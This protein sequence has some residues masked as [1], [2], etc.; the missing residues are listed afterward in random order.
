MNQDAAMHLQIV[1][2]TRDAC[3]MW[4]FFQ[5]INHGISVG[6]IDKMID[7]VRMFLEEEADIK[8]PFCTS[9][10]KTILRYNNGT[11]DRTRMKRA[12]TWGDCVSCAI[13]HL[14]ANL[15]GL[16]GEF[17]YAKIQIS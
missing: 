16:L 15:Q 14:P 3:E 7:I 11:F 9:D 2:Q 17:R 10:P 6:V 4:G 8:R 13:D 12:V 1:D 5:V